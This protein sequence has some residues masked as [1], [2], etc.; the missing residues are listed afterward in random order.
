MKQKQLIPVG[1]LAQ[2]NIHCELYVNLK[3][4][5]HNRNACLK[6]GELVTILQCARFNPTTKDLILYYKV[7]TQDGTIGWHPVETFKALPRS[8]IRRNGHNP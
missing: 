6:Q 4:G 8:H 3:V 5:D 7:L 2:A 1:S